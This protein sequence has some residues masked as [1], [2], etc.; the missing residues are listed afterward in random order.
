MSASPAERDGIVCAEPGCNGSIEATVPLWL[1]LSADGEW[2]V[3]GAGDEAAHIVCDQAAH[4][5]STV[6]LRKSLTAFLNE[7]FPGRTWPI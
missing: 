5:N 6:V 3:H 1:T 7:L 4:P 2:F